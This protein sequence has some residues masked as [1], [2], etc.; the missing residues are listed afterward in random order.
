M[1]V[2]FKH[3]PVLQLPDVSANFEQL[4]GLLQPSVVSSLP[5]LAVDGQEV[6][7]Q[8]AAMAEA[9]VVWHLKY[10]SASASTHKWEYVGGAAWLNEVAAEQGRASASYG[11]LATVGPSIIVPL[12]GDYCIDLR[13]QVLSNGVELAIVGV[14][15]GS[16]E[17]GS[18]D[19]AGGGIGTQRVWASRQG[20][21]VNI[22]ATA[23]V[24]LQYRGTSAAEMKFTERT[25]SLLP[26][27]V[28]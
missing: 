25:L 6:F 24:K 7:Y 26:I 20:V 5:V 19:F 13:A 10:R 27:R 3:L 11:D 1:P 12:A 8:N 14:K 9:G 18:P 2:S 16:A 28:G 23:V 4:M 21:L 15:V 22:A 17:A